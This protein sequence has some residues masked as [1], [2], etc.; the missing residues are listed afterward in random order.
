ML[1]PGHQCF[2]PLQ[3]AHPPRWNPHPSAVEVE[4]ELACSHA[5]AAEA[6]LACTRGAATDLAGYHGGA[7]WGRGGDGVVGSRAAVMEA[8]R[9]HPRDR[10]G[11]RRLP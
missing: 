9:L 4:A 7:A 1:P 11:P 6:E 8:E 10:D 2:I 5:A 3:N